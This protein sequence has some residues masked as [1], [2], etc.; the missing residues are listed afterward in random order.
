VDSGNFNALSFAKSVVGGSRVD[1]SRVDTSSEGPEVAPPH[2]HDQ[3]SHYLE[4]QLRV[5]ED[6]IMVATRCIDDTHALVTDYCW[7]AS[8][9]HDS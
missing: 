7:R 9:S 1:T 3:E 5:S 4:G 6:M 2:D 8:V